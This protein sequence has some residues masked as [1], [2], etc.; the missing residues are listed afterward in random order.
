M[1]RT[2]LLR[3]G[4]LPA[5]GGGGDDDDGDEGEKDGL[6]SVGGGNGGV[7]G[8]DSS[9]GTK[10]SAGKGVVGSSSSEGG[11]EALERFAAAQA[12]ASARGAATLRAKNEEIL[13]AV[14]ELVVLVR[15]HP[16]DGA[17]RR[18][19][20]ADGHSL[21]HAAQDLRQHYAQTVFVALLQCVKRSLG[22]VQA[23]VYESVAEAV[24]REKR[25]RRAS[26]VVFAL[27]ANRRGPVPP[28]SPA[29]LRSVAPPAPLFV[30]EVELGQDAPRYRPSLNAITSAVRAAAKRAMRVADAVFEWPSVGDDDD[31]TAA[32]GAGDDDGGVE[33]A[34]DGDSDADDEAAERRRRRRRAR[35][36]TSLY[37]RMT[38]TND[39]VRSV[40]LL[41]GSVSAL[42]AAPA[43][44]NGS[45]A[46][47]RSSA[48]VGNA[49]GS[50]AA[51][52]PLPS[53]AKYHDAL[54]CFDQLE[55]DVAAIADLHTVGALT[56]RLVPL[57]MQL[58]Q[59]AQ[60]WKALFSRNLLLQARAQVQAMAAD[61]RQTRR[62]IG[63]RVAAVAASAEEG[64]DDALLDELGEAMAMLARVRAAEATVD[65]KLA[66]VEQQYALLRRFTGVGSTAS[67]SDDGDAGS[68]F[69]GEAE[70]EALEAVR[71]D[72][73]HP[74]AAKG[75]RAYAVQ[76]MRKLANEA[77][78]Y[79]R[80]L[81]A[82]QGSFRNAVESSVVAFEAEG[83]LVPGLSTQAVL[84]A[85]RRFRDRARMLE[86]DLAKV[87][88]AEALFAMV[89]TRH[90][91]LTAMRKTLDTISKLWDLH[92]EFIERRDG[93]YRVGWSEV[94]ASVALSQAMALAKKKG[95][96]LPAPVP[97]GADRVD[98]AKDGTGEEA[99][100]LLEL[101]GKDVAAFYNRVKRLP[102]EV[103][104]RLA[105]QRF[106]E[107]RAAIEEYS[108]ALP[109][110]EM[111]AKPS[112]RPRHWNAISQ[113]LLEALV[114]EEKR[115]AAHGRIKESVA[116]AFSA[117]R[118]L[119]ARLA[120]AL[121]EPEDAGAGAAGGGAQGATDGAGAREAAPSAVHG[122]GAVTAAQEELK[123][124][125]L[126]A[127]GIVDLQADI[128][129]ITT[130]A[131][132]EIKVEKELDRVAATWEEAN[133]EFEPW[134][135]RKPPVFVLSPVRYAAIMEKLEEDQLVLQT[136]L[137]QRGCRP[138][139]ERAVALLESLSECS[140][141]LERWIKVQTMWCA[142]APV[143]IGGDIAKAMADVSRKFGQ[144]DKSWAKLMAR[145][146][147]T[148][149]CLVCTQAEA[150]LTA[151]PKLYSELERCHKSLEG[152]LEKKRDKFP[153]FYFVSGPKLLQ[154]LSQGSDPLSMNNYYEAVFDSI[155]RVDH[156]PKDKTAI[157]AMREVG[158]PDSGAVPFVETV[159]ATGNIEDWLAVLLGLMQATM[160]ELCR[161]VAGAARLSIATL[162]A[163]FERYAGGGDAGGADG[164]RK[165]G[166]GKKGKGGKG[167]GSTAVGEDG[168]GAG[169]MPPV[170]Q[171]KTAMPSL[172]AFVDSCVPQF[173]LL[174]I[175][176]MWTMDQQRALETARR[177]AHAMSLCAS[178]QLLELSALAS[179]CGE[180]GLRKPERKKL[181]TL[182]TVHVH[183]RDTTDELVSAW[184]ASKKTL[185]E[186]SFDWLKQARFTWTPHAHDACSDD[187]AAQIA[188]TDVT[189]DYQWEYLGSK[190]RL[191]ITPLTDRCYITLAQ[192][193]GM[194]FGGAPA[195]PAGTGKTETVKDLGCTLGIWVVVYNCTDQQSYRDC[196]KIFKGLCQSGLWGCFDEFNRIQLP[197]LSVVAQQVEAITKAKAVARAALG[198][199]R[200]ADSDDKEKGRRRGRPGGGGQRDGGNV[201][202]SAAPP[203][204]L[205]RFPGDSL[206]IALNP[207]CG[208]FITMNPGYAG[209][210][211]LPENLKALFRGVAMMVPDFEII[212]KV[213]LCSQG[214]GQYE[215]LAKKFFRLYD[216]SKEQ[217]SNQ[218]HY[219]W[220]LR[221]ILSVLRTAG[222]TK[223]AALKAAE[224]GPN[225]P[226]PVPCPSES[227]LLYQTLRD[228]NRSKLVAQDVPLFLS[229]LADLFPAEKTP[230]TRKH[231]ALMAA[232][233]DHARA[234]GLVLHDGWVVKAMQ[235][236]ETTL[237]RHG[238][239]LVGP[240]G[241]GKSSVMRTLRTALA[242]KCITG[243]AHRAA[244]INPKGITSHQMYGEMDP[245][246]GEWTNGVF[247]S[248][249]EKFN[250]RDNKF[251]TWL[252]CDGPVDA[253]WIEDLNT[254]LDDNKILTLANGDRFPMTDN[255][256]L[257]FEVETLV[258]ASPAT[259]SR[260]GIIYVSDTDLDWAPVAQAWVAS[261][262]K[263][264]RQG[265]ASERVA[266]V[267]EQL[268]ELLARYV[269]K[270]TPSTPGKGFDFLTRHTEPVMR[271][272]RVGTISRLT[273]LLGQLLGSMAAVTGGGD[274][275]GGAATSM[276]ASVVDSNGAGGDDGKRVASPVPVPAVDAVVVERLFTYAFAWS[277]GS[278]LETADRKRLDGY[279][280]GCADAGPHGAGVVMPPA[281]E[282]EGDEG[283][284]GYYVSERIGSGLG[285]WA[286][287]RPAL[288]ECP[289]TAVLD[290]SNVLVPT[291]DSTRALTLLKRLQLQGRRMPMLLLGG[292]GTAKSSTARMHLAALDG[293]QILS[294]TLNFSSATGP[295]AFQLS[296]EETLDKR[297]GKSFGPPNLKQLCLF[298]D[299]V[300][301][302]RVNAWG[303]Q[304]TL[305]AV[306][307]LVEHS[308]FPFLDKDK[309]GDL[310]LV[311]DLLYVAAMSHPTGGR[312]DV[313]MRFKRHFFMINIATP[314]IA[315]INAIYG[316]MLGGRFG[317]VADGAANNVQLSPAEMVAGGSVAFDPETLGVVDGFTRATIALWG[318]LKV[319]MLPT[320][321][322]F[323]YVFN[324]RD[325]AR[326]FQ[327]VL[328]TP[329]STV[330]GGGVGGGPDAA[331]ND[332]GTGESIAV[333]RPAAMLLA[334]WQHECARAMCDKLTT[335]QDKEW[336]QAKMEEVASAHFSAAL[337]E[338]AAARPPLMINFGRD[339]GVDD[340]TDEPVPAPK[341][342]ENGGSVTRVRGRTA[343]LL[344][345]HNEERPHATMGLVLFDDALEHLLRISRV[346]E[347]PR[348]SVLL[349][350]VGG[351]GKQ[352]LT[353]LASYIARAYHF[354]VTLTK[355]YNQNALLDDLRTLYEVA[356]QQRRQT[357]FLFTEAEIKDEMF[358]EV[359]N[360]VLMTGEVAGLFSKEE[361]LG[362]AADLAK[363]FR[364]ARPGLLETAEN[365]R[366]YLIDCVRD[367]LHVVLCMSPMSPKFAERARR[368]PGLFAAPLIDWFLPWPQEALVAVSR[369]FIAD[370]RHP[371][372]AANAAPPSPDD[373]AAVARAALAGQPVLECTEKER[374]A[375]MHHMGSVH[376]LATN[377]CPEYFEAMRRHVY[378][379]P[380]SYLSFLSS[381]KAMYARKLAA[382]KQ[383]ER[384]VGVGLQKLAA[385]AKDVEKMSEALDK[386]KRV[387]EEKSA[388]ANKK[389][390]E[391]QVAQAEGK[392]VQDK[393]SAIVAKNKQVAARI[394]EE[395]DECMREFEAARPWQDKADAAIK[396][397]NAAQIKD[398]RNM[399]SRNP[400]P[401]IRFLME[402]LCILFG[403]PCLK[404][405][406]PKSSQEI[407]FSG[408]VAPWRDLD[409]G[410]D[411]GCKA[412]LN[413]PDF[414]DMLIKFGD[415]GG[416]KDQ[417]NDETVELLLPYLELRMAGVKNEA[418]AAEDGTL[419]A[420]HRKF[421]AG[422]CG[423]AVTLMEYAEAMKG[424]H[425]ASKV[426]K[427]KLEALKVAEAKLS[428]AVADQRTAEAQLDKCNAE[429]R[430]LEDDLDATMKEKKAL[431][432]QARATERTMNRASEL[433]GGLGGEQIRWTED[434]KRFAQTKT[435][436]VGDCAVA[437]A[438]VS[439]CGPF[440]QHY[441]E[442][443]VER[444]FLRDARE[445]SV[446]VS[447]TCDVV[448]FLVERADLAR[449][450]I[451]GLPTDGLSSQNG[452]L[453]AKA[454]ATRFPLLVDPQGQA[455][456]WLF[457]HEAERLP[458]VEK[459]LQGTTTAAHPKFKEQLQY[460]LENGKAL[461]ASVVSSPDEI[462]PMLDPVLERH[463]V[464][465]RSGATVKVADTDMD[466]H[467]DFRLYFVTRLPNPHISPELQA[468]T[469][470][471]DFTVTQNGLEE[472]LL[473]RVIKREQRALEEQLARVLEEV[474][475]NTMALIE[476]DDKLLQQLSANDGSLLED[477]T[478]VTL[479]QTTK[480]KA[481]EVEE[482]LSAAEVTK[483]S[484]NE[485]RE[486]FRPVATRGAVLYFSI[487]EMSLVN[488]MYQT[489]LAQFLQL[490]MRSMDEAEKA[491]LAQK[492]VANIVEKLTWVSYRYI[493]RGLY[494][495]DKLL[496]VLLLTLKALVRD[497]SV[498][499]TPHDVALLLRGGAALD[500]ARERK[501]PAPWLPD[502]AWLGVLALANAGAERAPLHVFREL[503]TKLG[504]NQTQ[505]RE[506]LGAAEPEALQVPDIEGSLGVSVGVSAEA[507]DGDGA[508]EGG[509]AT[510]AGDVAESAGGFSAQCLG[511]F[512]RLLVVRALRVDRLPLACRAFIRAVPPAVTGPRYAAPAIDTLEEVYDEMSAAPH[513]PVIFL[514]SVGADPTESINTLAHKRKLPPPFTVS[515]G[516]G[517]EPV[518]LRAI[519][520]AAVGGGDGGDGGDGGASAGGQGGGAGGRSGTSGWV[521][522]Q[523]CELGLPLMEKMEGELQTL[524]EAEGS[525]DEAFRLFITAL[526]HPQFPLGLL[527]MSTKVTNAPP[528]GLRAGLSKS[529]AVTVDQ[530]RLDKVETRQGRKLLFMLSFLHSVVQERV[531][532]GALGW[533]VPYEFNTGDLVACLK[534]MEKHMAEG[535]GTGAPGMGVTFHVSW[536][537]LRYMVA[538]VQYG[539]KVT[540]S[541]DRRLLVLYAKQWLC[542]EA[543]EDGYSYSPAKSLQAG[544][545]FPYTVPG[546]E[547]IEVRVSCALEETQPKGGGGGG[548]EGGGSDAAVLG[549]AARL[550]E[551]LPTDYQAEV[552]KTTIETDPKHGRGGLSVPLNIFLYQELQRMKAVVHAVRVTLEQLQLAVQ[553]EVVMT[554][555]LQDAFNALVES[556]VPQCWVFTVA[557]DEFSWILP[558]MGLWSVS[559]VQARRIV[560]TQC[561]VFGLL[562]AMKQEVTR[563]HRPQHWALDDVMYHTEVCP[564]VDA[565]AGPSA[566][567][568]VEG[569]YVTGLFLD[570][571]TYAAPSG[572][573]A[574][575]QPGG[576]TDPKAARAAQGQLAE[577]EPK[578]LFSALPT[579]LVSANQRVLEEKSRRAQFGAAGP[580]ECPLFKY[581]ARGDRYYVLTVNLNCPPGKGPTFW[582]LRGVALLCNI[583]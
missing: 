199:G 257:L 486:Q 543:L 251:N 220:G 317:C 334:L 464:V 92:V 412:M 63:A 368:F 343:A 36:K 440:N 120:S 171:A 25:A 360:S 425:E 457:K 406:L 165:G 423:Q 347:M 35:A 396:N 342:Y 300:S 147:E 136:C 201:S 399:C 80:K 168:E 86:A 380:K 354:Q 378:Q 284:F 379:T 493:N 452:I 269:G 290:F 280:R 155:D 97:E 243:K 112:M 130:T 311:E 430:T 373:T 421:A 496:F 194:L 118:Q 433:I 56:L 128:E 319:K 7:G 157:L 192:A 458:N 43:A 444:L 512:L 565:T 170:A 553:G 160:K 148:K 6:V 554:A 271:S 530:D 70:L 478:L 238:I 465:K 260:A 178:K 117:R 151:L 187:G 228:M 266:A 431:E 285:Q 13:R 29:L 184:R 377:V 15:A 49:S 482:K 125:D 230:A 547:A 216:T 541:F 459:L 306:R 273:A 312:N 367:N 370:W 213:K 537:T 533:S 388:A 511:A 27:T 426:V 195:G 504:S 472:Q 371:Q 441:R 402:Y 175:Q 173:A 469:T 420:F 106:K 551:D 44:A 53:I 198:S 140:E 552:F 329:R 12:Q 353:R 71:M 363:P 359:L 501:K 557:G 46:R 424:Y 403:E 158:A 428:A 47:A 105:P 564:H 72:W 154:I 9:G 324:L 272:S 522:L 381:Y 571:G 18:Q 282:G 304:E 176:M 126:I 548:G 189:F 263:G 234:C 448:D 166:K 578:I 232:F 34:G 134:K 422:A 340:E 346:I 308:Y 443:C 521:L 219:D 150:L 574:Q 498:S 39:I 357:V 52:A 514:L 566:E 202:S 37:S 376:H 337:A 108:K 221:N 338:E 556:K 503:P 513:V 51:T 563:A 356:G 476:L 451:E 124:Y 540:Q 85:L 419:P 575:A 23:H 102:R 506:W 411:S 279:M 313:P 258:N 65:A 330:M 5:G 207:A 229:L 516:E 562:T 309:R 558:T 109:L 401:F 445:R 252:I 577:S 333:M 254:V 261:V 397:L 214:Y 307:L 352:S 289:T 132:K 366:Q 4:I 181:E 182:V 205:F 255:V 218:K 318:A 265:G 115:M 314:S 555:E 434:A 365:L 21:D 534:F 78:V 133:F 497:E 2:R 336:Y 546:G 264:A 491:G 22:R 64:D 495:Q 76:Q 344:R 45:R 437:C 288:W 410:W 416:G 489:S 529:F 523:N 462:D 191:V 42:K 471:I 447:E 177:N 89:R 94:V 463:V 519:R 485:K 545:F 331:G 509:G 188:I 146:L 301:M 292:P 28:P 345:M 226:N 569:V 281:S 386:Q 246:S 439:Y 335:T 364:A 211:E 484:I 576:G 206:N 492:R 55:K 524:R 398:L 116:V 82:K 350:G 204:T 573:A 91:K 500:I 30:V 10:G 321:A 414:L 475:L 404:E 429:L 270:C 172:R 83:P 275:S 341:V 152:Y 400:P 515:L 8:G 305:E 531:K 450:Q 499:I 395:K 294:K 278:L 225:N 580:F 121:G 568:R 355:T 413:R 384:R 123:L 222:A 375:L 50:S 93:W 389:L 114:E 240:T 141:T 233:S 502:E 449:W 185:D 393:V 467:P 3:L 227:A 323:H 470:V 544:E 579:L 328:L 520:N 250:K 383:Q 480:S 16:A 19:W 442:H 391:V 87:N 145:A 75:L 48:S 217:L 84:D 59:Q 427:P 474:N 183:Q 104:E 74:D 209:R 129:D 283:V 253:I 349:V 461:I 508:D 41:E 68:P 382:I 197:V 73:R 302:P 326:V 561:E 180:E 60:A 436:L 362:M 460:C 162:D 297:P 179:F 490:F 156:D 99:L 110:Y 203:P 536:T 327:G 122:G 161:D 296:V 550:L 392:E 24:Q 241:G 164:E 528:A 247:A 223:R 153:R 235:L 144:I 409:L 315:T 26:Q 127:A 237:V 103:K 466:W 417:M 494:E 535:A 193:L 69:V 249:W 372:A 143:F 200:A 66:P 581:A 245:V 525:I 262:G 390:A 293:G 510:A 570:G 256:K 101:M 560:R 212:M 167:K 320:P 310:K 267:R 572:G 408:C 210:Q 387:V 407:K 481:H 507:G 299:D 208:Y 95:K 149:S 286:A 374:L 454:Q 358:L 40:L 174:G 259:V 248:M 291:V 351:S 453:V 303:D 479:L 11:D 332:G 242:D 163:E 38:K 527:Q 81:V 532:F 33:E 583:E 139:R 98:E 113:L 276:G 415:E 61:F 295:N 455:V 62:V 287:W 159:R 418:D 111:L 31:G 483:A 268:G 142:L 79:R 567:E 100:P 322:K 446:P 119:A 339:D 325:L 559:R 526:P 107:L 57:K 517:Q 438:F 473:G 224:P 17:L 542:A 435:R 487:V 468:K 298:I 274:E 394:G 432:D 190:E 369:A 488:A 20:I 169:G 582:G 88:N 518:A 32:A 456:A 477:E 54:F 1:A 231:P 186:T 539:G 361:L 405:L 96:L 277:F 196:A 137:T 239:M 348:G 135:D 138:F 14:R 385:G 58:T 131:D 67:D 90:P 77:K 505:W 538:E 549:E 236:Y 316:Q 215:M 244:I